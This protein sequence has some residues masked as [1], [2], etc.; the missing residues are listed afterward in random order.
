MVAS[1]HLDGE[2]VAPEGVDEAPLA[3]QLH[4]PRVQLVPGEVS[5]AVCFIERDLV[6]VPERLQQ[7]QASGHQSSPQLFGSFRHSR[8]GTSKIAGSRYWWASGTGFFGSG[9]GTTFFGSGRVDAPPAGAAG[10]GAGGSSL[11]S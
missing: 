10:L 6:A 8:S 11:G 1:A 2:P 5:W 3:R 9:G 4:H 7:V